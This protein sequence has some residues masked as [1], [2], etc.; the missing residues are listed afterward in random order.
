MREVR[1]VLTMRAMSVRIGADIE[2]I[3]GKCGDVWHVVVA[4]EG[5]R[6]VK[7]Q[8]KQC[9]GYHRYRPPAG[10]KPA[11][12]RT[13]STTSRAR[14]SAKAAP[15]SKAPVMEVAPADR[16]ARPYSPKTRFEP[17]D[18]VLHPTF[19]QGVVQTVPAPGKMEVFFEGG[20]KLLVHAR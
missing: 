17:G 15:K 5:D 9:G 6:V 10:Q 7:V 16:P 4:A 14:K 3:C 2:S 8:C 13:T 1:S 18:T 19:G 12:S 11:S 20:P